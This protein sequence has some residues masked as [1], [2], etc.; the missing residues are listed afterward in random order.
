MA[1][2][3][4]DPDDDRFAYSTKALARLTLSHQLAELADRAAALVP[5]TGDAG[6]HP[7]EF[8]AAVRALAAMAEDA[9]ARAVIYER[10]K[11]TSWE[12]LGESLGD[13]TRQSAHGKFRE[14]VAEWGQALH[15]PLYPMRGGV[16]RDL[17]LPEAAYRPTE[18]RH[19]LDQWAR[20]HGGYE[21]GQPVSDGLAEL[22]TLEEMNQV[23]AGLEHVYR[24]PLTVDKAKVAQML[25][26][27]AALLE[28]IG[29]EENRPEATE[30]AA[31]TRA[32]AAALR[33]GQ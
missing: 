31:E 2:E 9:L 33:S 15:E 13:I 14:D 6:A 23:L 22:S 1:S 4:I 26:R 29:Q 8:V 16:I 24:N 12:V 21:A 32:R 5:T 17:R 28:R 3:M 19:R 7:G 25:D 11:S 18:T 10:E 30:Q 27:K 20:K